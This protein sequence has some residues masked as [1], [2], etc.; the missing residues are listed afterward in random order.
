[1]AGEIITHALEA[2]DVREGLP[3][4]SP[5]P[6]PSRVE[7]GFDPSA[8][9]PFS[10][11]IL[12]AATIAL[13]LVRIALTYPVFFQ[14]CDEPFHF[15]CGMAW[16]DLGR[17]GDPAA[18]VPAACFEAPPLAPAATAALPYLAGLRSRG[19]PKM[20]SEGNAILRSG[21]SYLRN[22]TLARIGIL[23]FFVLAAGVIWAW[24]RRLFG[25]RTAL[26][27]VFLFCA[28]P[29]ILGH[30]GLATTDMAATAGIVSAVF[31][32]EVWLKKAT[33]RQSAL[34]GVS[35]AFA[36]LSKLSALLFLP[37]CL[38]SLLALRWALERP[39][40]AELRRGL[41]SHVGPG[42]L[43]LVTAF[44]AI[45]S[46]YHFTWA[47]L[48]T[49]EKR[50]H[51]AHVTRFLGDHPRWQDVVDRLAE[52]P[53][54]AGDLFRGVMKV[55]A[56][57]ARGHD[58]YLLG[59][60]RK[61]GWWYFFP[62][63]LGVKTPLAFLLLLAAGI[64]ALTRMPGKRQPE[65]W[66]P[67]VCALAIL[68]VVLPSRINIGVRHVL[69]IYP[70][71]SIT[72]GVGLATLFRHGRANRWILAAAYALLLWFSASSAMAHPDYLAYF[73]ELGGAHPERIVVDSDLDWGQDLWRLSRRLRQVGAP[74]VTLDYF[75]SEDI[76]DQGLPA[77]R[78]LVPYQPAEGWIAISEF[79]LTVGAED[80]RKKA[81]RDEHPYAWLLDKP[82]TRV[83]KSIRLYHVVP[84]D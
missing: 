37:V 11:R 44:V 84:G 36:V 83:G 79:S 71:L 61:D 65:R 28:L 77:V 41:K 9:T 16:M 25:D 78:P 74:L 49:V 12:L 60:Y 51:L 69:A 32:F 29:P 55:R 38:V 76:Y 26:G 14:T 33:L 22:L 73:N 48:T 27:A 5:P 35:L 13:A 62:V 39:T 50:P 15:A 47:P 80:V 6:L 72:A 59:N 42:A 1:M 63:V 24:A 67:V 7:P 20:D 19:V 70:F 17:T 23:P 52:T 30:A 40:G 2:A 8:A 4:P 53:L 66:S 57:N 81:Q 56:H 31:A 3:P 46:A 21:G 64:W 68:I 45:W 18:R 54:P 82:Y 58:G 43:A 10:L 75:G 34:L